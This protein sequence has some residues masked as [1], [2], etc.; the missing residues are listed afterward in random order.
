ML[1]WNDKSLSNLLHFQN[2]CSVID[3]HYLCHLKTPCCEGW[4]IRG[5]SLSRG[6]RA[7]S[8]TTFF[9]WSWCLHLLG[10]FLVACICAWCHFLGVWLYS[11]YNIGCQKFERVLS[12]I[13]PSRLV[14]SIFFAILHC[15]SYLW[16]RVSR[17][18]LLHYNEGS[19]FVLR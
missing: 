1:M 19:V 5:Q 17:W 3:R 18:G 9:A 12:L 4:Y 2:F 14:K 7:F 6:F 16:E 10:N 8:C 11:N 13:L 15:Q